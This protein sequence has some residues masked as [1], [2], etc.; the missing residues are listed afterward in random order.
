R[1]SKPLVIGVT[2]CDDYNA[3][4]GGIDIADGQY[5]ITQALNQTAHGGTGGTAGLVVIGLGISE[6]AGWGQAAHLSPL[7]N[8]EGCDLMTTLVHEY[9]H[10]LGISSSG[11]ES[12]SSAF[13]NETGTVSLW[14]SH[15]YDRYGTQAQANMRIVLYEEGQSYDGTV[16]VSGTKA[17]SGVTF[18][19]EH[20]SEVLQGALGGGL[21]VNG[22]EGDTAELS[23]IELDHSLMSH[24]Y[25]RNWNTLMEAELA[26]LQDLGYRIDR[27][28]WYGYSVY[29]SGL[30]L[31]NTNGYWARNAAG[32]AYLE[33][34]ANT[35]TLGTGLHIYGS[36]NT[37]TQA[38]DL[39]ACG[40]AGTGIRVDGTGNTLA[41]A[42][43]VT[44]TADGDWGTGLLVAYGKDQIVVN[45][46]SVTATGTGGVAV[47]FDFGSN[48]LGD[49]VMEYRGSW[50]WKSYASCQDGVVVNTSLTV[51]NGLDAHGF[52]LNLDGAMVSRFALSGSIEGSAAAI[53][54][55]DNAW[56]KQIDI[57]SGASIRGDILSGW[58]PENELVQY[59]TLNAG[60]S[61]TELT[62]LLTFGRETLASGLGGD[63]GDAAFSLVYGGAISG[64]KSI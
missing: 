8:G 48:M 47:R 49:N 27:R 43:G 63:N 46:G 19:G 64:A 5:S 58:D 39:L 61:D 33:G 35:A 53:Y 28:N 29:G 31:T 37:V 14:D 9:S 44:V 56:V 51:N 17:R 41:V 32:T 30:T 23:H 16:F 62:T 38:A 54:I 7:G 40:T 11:A 59:A 1:N 12:E 6:S 50:M 15:L 26:A 55:A 13:T 20:V 10:L 22:F 18:R 2:T 24:Q 36:N 52:P 60:H 21:P 34:Q 25:W 45:Q 3:Y 4:A 57:L 42:E